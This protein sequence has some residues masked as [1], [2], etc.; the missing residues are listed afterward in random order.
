M[1]WMYEMKFI[2][3]IL[4]Y[5]FGKCKKILRKLYILWWNNTCSIKK[6]S[7]KENIGYDDIS[8]NE[9]VKPEIIRFVL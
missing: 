2:N 1:S 4:A 3:N 8:N 7:G 6:I 9:N 5:R